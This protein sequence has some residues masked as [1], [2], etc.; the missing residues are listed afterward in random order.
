MLR[1]SN[2]IPLDKKS[3]EV[4]YKLHPLEINDVALRGFRIQY[5]MLITLAAA[6]N[7]PTVLYVAARL[8]RP[9]NRCYKSSAKSML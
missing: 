7:R 1:I 8:T 4:T 9:R 3:T 6:W 2:Q 5:F